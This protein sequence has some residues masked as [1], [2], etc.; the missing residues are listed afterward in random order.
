MSKPIIIVDKDE[1][2]KMRALLRGDELEI[3]LA[4]GAAV[5]S[6]VEAFRAQK[7]LQIRGARFKLRHYA[8]KYIAY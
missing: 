2:G 6:V 5:S 7:N 4:L 8:V 1:N 3:T